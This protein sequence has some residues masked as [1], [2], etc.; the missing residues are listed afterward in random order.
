MT[1]L[2]LQVRLR[3]F[4][5]EKQLLANQQYQVMAQ[6][7]SAAFGGGGDSEGSS[8]DEA[9]K[10]GAEALAMFATLKL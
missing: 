3:L 1:Y 5:G 4:V 7:V 9:P 2:D 10:T 6:V 8:S